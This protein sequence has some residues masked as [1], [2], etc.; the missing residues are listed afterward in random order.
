MKKLQRKEKI[1]QWDFIQEFIHNKIKTLNKK[2]IV[3]MF[4]TSVRGGKAFAAKQKIREP[5]KKE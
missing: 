4:S 5:K 1:N 2:Y 3:K